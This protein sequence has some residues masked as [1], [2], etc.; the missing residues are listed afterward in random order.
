[1]RYML[2]MKASR[3]SEAGI[4]PSAASIDAMNAY[5]AELTQAGV[6]LAAEWL[7]PSSSGMRMI[8]PKAGDRPTFVSGPIDN[9]NELAAGYTIIDVASEEEAIAWAKRAPDPNGYGEGVIDF[10]RMLDEPGA[11]PLSK[12]NISY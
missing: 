1:M 9:V 3:H 11:R 6:L 5:Y 4:P 8:Y 2:V 12:L 7:Y 10:H